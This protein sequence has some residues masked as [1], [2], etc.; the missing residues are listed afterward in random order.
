[1]EIIYPNETL[2]KSFHET[3]DSVAREQI[4]IEMIEAKPFE[5]ISAFQRKLIANNW[6]VYYAVTDGRVVGWADITPASNPRMAHRGFL[7]MGLIKDFRGRGLGTQLLSKALSH[8]KRI[9]LEKVELSV[10]TENEAAIRLYKKCGFREIG[11]VKNF[12]KLNG[13]YFDC[14]EME[15][16]FEV[17]KLVPKF[18]TDRLI[19][20]GVTLEDEPSYKKNFVDY[21][22]I[23]HLSAAVPWPYPENGIKDFIQ[24][25]II[26]N[27]GKDHWIWGLFLKEE[28]DE[29]VGVVDLW[30]EGRPENRGFWLARRHWGKGLMTEA[31]RPIMDYAFREL[32]FEKLVFANALG[33]RSSRRI[34]EKT[35]AKLIDVRDAKFVDPQ[36]TKHEIWELTKGD[37][38]K[39]SETP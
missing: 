37:W 19:L 14:I 36:Y 29:L 2:F 34:K 15:L 20:R 7:G 39:F 10:Y 9:G 17:D 13:R 24:R 27:Q 23:R 31:V 5:E 25:Y 26:P 33:N 12:R 8:A 22:V 32:N 38:Y 21:E 6:P 11:L 30:R 3:L 1:M 4:Y 16:F 28:P 35:G 18:E